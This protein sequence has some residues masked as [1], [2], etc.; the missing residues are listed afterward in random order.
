MVSLEDE[1]FNPKIEKHELMHAIGFYH[2]QS[3]TDRDDYVVVHFDNVEFGNIYS[4]KFMKYL[5]KLNI[6]LIIGLD[7]NF[8][9]YDSTQVQ[10][11]RTPYDISKRFLKC[12]D[13]LINFYFEA[14]S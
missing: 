8:Q 5:Y 6:N 12:K 2:E 11:L 1:C 13:L 7:G 10:S 9:K 14:Y 3:R 4:K